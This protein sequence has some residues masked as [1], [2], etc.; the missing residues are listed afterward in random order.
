MCHMVREGHAGHGDDRRSLVRSH[1]GRS[2]RG[3]GFRHYSATA[4]DIEEFY[5]ADE[6]RRRSAEIELG[7][8]WR[9]AAGVRHELSWVQDTGELY[10]MRE[11]V[12]AVWEDPFGD[13]IV[14]QASVH[15]ESVAVIGVIPT[16]EE[17]D[18]VLDGWSEAMEEPRGVEWIAE[19]LR[20]R[21]VTPPAGPAPSAAGPG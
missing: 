10:V 5:D 13:M 7:T 1:R 12:P 4:M 20:S 2:G 15:D 8:E 11:P 19:R 18:Q 9:D 21:G 3:L 17:L 16:Q 6:R 14:D